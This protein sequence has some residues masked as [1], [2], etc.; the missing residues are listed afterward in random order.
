MNKI[1]MILTLIGVIFITIINILCISLFISVD[2]GMILALAMLGLI[3]VGV[4]LRLYIY[5]N[6]TRG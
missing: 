2:I 5:S 4:L 6:K 1:K 3:I